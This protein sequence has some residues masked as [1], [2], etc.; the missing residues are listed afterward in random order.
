MVLPLR[1][2]DAVK[3]VFVVPNRRSWNSSCFAIIEV[4]LTCCRGFRG[5]SVRGGE[6]HQEPH[7][8]REHQSNTSLV[9]TLS[10]SCHS[11]LPVLLPLMV[12]RNLRLYGTR[13]RG[14]ERCQLGH[15]AEM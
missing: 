8:P 9:R 14:L 1:S 3:G 7:A 12:S 2:I 6:C 5:P 11:C 15:K 13:P 10:L 4:L